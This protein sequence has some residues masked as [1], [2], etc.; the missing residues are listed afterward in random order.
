MSGALEGL[1]VLELAESISGPYCGKLMAG[2]GAE[3]IKVEPPQ[4]DAA[5]RVGPFPKDTPDNEAS[6][7]FL[8]LNTGKK[9][10]TLDLQLQ[11][12]REQFLHLAENMDVVVENHRP[13]WLDS[14]ALGYGDL[15]RAN[16]R[17]VM[18]SITPFGQFGPYRDFHSTNMVIHALSGE[19]YGSGNPDREP[20]SKGGKLAEHHGALHGYLGALS[21]L[22]ARNTTGR[23]QH[24]DVSVH[25]CTTSI[26]GEFVK[27][28]VYSG[29]VAKRRNAR[30]GAWPA[31]VWQAQNG[32]A[33][34]NG[35]Q[36]VDAW[37]VFIKMMADVPQF[38]D[39]KYV[40]AEGKEQFAQEL[41]ALF[42]SWLSEHTKQEL[43]H[44]AQQNG[45]P[46]GY[47]ATAPDLLNSPQLQAR[48]FFVDIDHPIAGKLPYPGAPYEMHK[49]AFAFDRAPLLGEHNEEILSRGIQGSPSSEPKSSGLDS[50]LMPLQGVRVLDFSHIWA[51]PY[52]ARLLGDL[53]AEVIKVE[54]ISRNDIERGP[55]KVAPG[56]GR[57]Y[58]NGDPGE[59]PYNRAGRFNAYG[60]NKLG[61]TLDLR[62]DEGRALIRELIAVSDVVV[63][64]FSVGVMKRLGLDY[65]DCQA[66]RPDIVY[67][68]LPGFGRDG[69]EAG[70]AAMGITQE[71]MSGLSSITGY[72]GG[73]PMGTG[74][75]YGDPTGGVFG[76]TAV[77]TALH[78]RQ[79]SGEGQLID[80]S[81]REAFISILPDSIFEYTMNG[82]VM[83]SVGNR[84][85][86]F[87]PHGCY[88][89]KG[90][91]FWV[92]INVV[93]EDQFEALCKVVGENPPTL[94][95]EDVGKLLR[96]PCF[97][98][99]ASRKLNEDDL[100][101]LIQSWTGK[102]ESYEVMHL[103]QKAGIPAG[104]VLTN[105]QLLE[106]PHLQARGFFEVVT[107][108]DAGTHP[109]IGMPWKLSDTP[110]H[111]RLPA[112]CLGQHNDYILGD[113]LGV[114]QVQLERLASKDIIGL[115]R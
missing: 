77:L 79:R 21:A 59:R 14:L 29:V 40:T 54:S 27:R 63:E 81:Q 48:Q 52:C 23:G 51:G 101:H 57:T 78:H 31:G 105:Q 111:I 53:G 115:R 19:L 70:D 7:S 100:D 99:L 50:N 44:L 45:L 97:K 62:T 93:T 39:P 24:V 84:H 60:R 83:E 2:L 10:V 41:D 6:G 66:L 3:V 4:G 30:G 96:A 94:N 98:D 76:A 34:S 89:C 73:P 36:S 61:L 28:W 35:R 8:Y 15:A 33:I 113:I 68:S 12:D 16:P 11:C 65:E 20:L 46:Y 49:T 92:V 82:R 95:G 9:S 58:P 86:Q 104:A 91:D 13:G 75:I 38:A 80:L 22:Y 110:V 37:A 107:H 5:R 47:V 102:L 87:A 72:P 1:R 64:N 26:M 17:L 42:Q 32:Y 88:R 114:D 56:A 103:L 112:P 106:D 67:I 109:N 18:V 69:P 55:A 90:D 43:Y 74:V 71:A 25:E 85:A 108:P